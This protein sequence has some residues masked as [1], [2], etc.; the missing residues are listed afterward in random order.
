M[1]SI[2]DQLRRWQLLLVAALF[3]FGAHRYFTQV[4]TYG[5][6]G[7]SVQLDGFYYYIYLH[8]A[9][10]RGDLDL[11][12]DYDLH[13]YS[14][15]YKETPTGRPGNPFA[16]GPAL[17]W[18]PFW[19]LAHALLWLW[20]KL[21][22]AGYSLNPMSEA[23]QTLTLF[24]TYLYGCGAIYFCY[25]LARRLVPASSA[26]LAALC[27]GLGSPLIYYMLLSS[28]YSH[29]QSAFC[30]SAMVWSWIA[31]REQMTPRRGAALGALAGLTTLVHPGNA[32]LC[33]LP[34]G[35]FLA[36]VLIAL[37]RGSPRDA[38][39][40]LLTLGL[41]TATAVALFTPQMLAWKAIYGRYL[42]TPQ[43]EGFM[44]WS[45]SLWLATLFAPRNGLF[46]HAPVLALGLVGLLLLLRRH[47]RLGLPALLSLSL[48]ALVNGAVYD[49]WGWG[50]GARRYTVALPLFTLGIAHAAHG[51][52]RLVE[53]HRERISRGLV[54][55][56]LLLLAGV[57]L[58]LL[59][60]FARG[61]LTGSELVPS[62]ET[63]RIA[64]S[65]ATEDW[66]ERLGNPLSFPANWAFALRYGVDPG[67]YDKV[68]GFNF[69]D[70][71][72]AGANPHDLKLSDKLDLTREWPERFLLQGWG[73]VST[74][75]GGKARPARLARVKFLLPLNVHRGINL[76]LH[77]KP[78]IAGTSLRV[79]V[80]GQQ[81][82]Y[83]KLKEGWQVV[84]ARVPPAALLRGMNLVTLE[85]EAPA[86]VKVGQHRPRTVGSTGHTSPVDIAAV[87]ASVAQGDFAD[88]WVDGRRQCANR[89]GLNLTAVD[90]DS[91]KV[92]AARGFDVHRDAFSSRALLRF[93]N[94]LPDG[95]LVAVASRDE[96]S[97]NFNDDTRAALS[98]LGAQVNLAGKFRHTYA[99]VGVKGAA[100][101]TALEQT[102][103]KA[104][105]HA[106]IGRAPPPWRVFA[107]Y[108]K[109]ELRMDDD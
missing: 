14:V 77:L 3:L 28:S 81:A 99:A 67:R 31:W 46:P 76:A 13:G 40:P 12:D 84:G 27:A 106:F 66:F 82:G 96:A 72:H 33:V 38:L 75:A 43:G 7:G 59:R 11:K 103:A 54:P 98:Q 63:Y 25:R 95:T 90:P 48:L 29:A 36:P 97:R 5:Q 100:P 17:L 19:L 89:R 74:A 52:A 80:N 26:L 57:N 30:F 86:G 16:V 49:W 68:Y 34:A 8:S 91:G 71:N 109:C 20:V 41:A 45:E 21:G 64:F 105:A 78:E 79:L 87:G 61:S 32:V 83:R 18:A 22:N 42:L 9:L 44:R 69:L 56:L 94:S 107:S 35:T 53:H 4:D 58:L 101:G 88:I 92:L 102:R 93:V 6:Q 55:A 2:V 23:H 50:F 73:E 104:R 85:H 62:R 47:P 10:S 51:L 24:S 1:A 108:G 37:R 39:R 15:K 60:E 65:G 70:D